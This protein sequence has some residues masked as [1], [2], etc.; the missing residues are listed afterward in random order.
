MRATLPFGLVLAL[1]CGGGGGNDDGDPGVDA[2]VNEPIINGKPASEF[3]G[4]FAHTVTGAGM[5]GAA[6][7]PSQGDGRNAYHVTFFLMPNNKLELFYAEGEGEVTTT[8]HSLAIYNDSKK[9]RSGTWRVDGAELVLDTHMRCT[10]FTF[11]DRDVLRCTLTN[12]IIT[13]AAQGRAGT[14]KPG[15]AASPDDSEFADYV[16]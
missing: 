11:N 2:A 7:F 15:F 6:A 13:A 16:R 9:R 3:Y 10:S 14:F 12:P 8:G 4:Q 1:G 5:G